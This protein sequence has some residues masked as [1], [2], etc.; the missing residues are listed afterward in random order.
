MQ[1]RPAHILLLLLGMPIAGCSSSAPTLAAPIHVTSGPV[2]GVANGPVVNIALKFGS[3]FDP[4]AMH[5]FSVDDFTFHARNFCPRPQAN[6]TSVIGAGTYA[7]GRLQCHAFAFY[8]WPNAIRGM[9]H[10]H[11]L[12]VAY[13]C[14]AFCAS[15]LGPETHGKGFIFKP[16]YLVLSP[17]GKTLPFESLSFGTLKSSRAAARAS[18]YVERIAVQRPAP[19]QGIA[20]V[21]SD[22]SPDVHVCSDDIACDGTATTVT[23]AGGSRTALFYLSPFRHANGL[24]KHRFSITAVAKGCETG[25]DAG[26]ILYQP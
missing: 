16:P 4:N 22:S 19:R 11:R 25:T 18:I 5:G 10:W 2:E 13:A 23:I 26:T 6:A 1:R 24:G 15:S 12:S 14:G 21:L 3:R 8:F 9:P 7:N 17:A 20:V